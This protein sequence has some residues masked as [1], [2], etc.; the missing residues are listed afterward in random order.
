MDT[1][2][3]VGVHITNRLEEA[4]DVQ[5]VLT[6]YG[7]QIK[8]RLGLHEIEKNPEELNGLLILEMVGEEAKV[9][10]M[11]GKLNGIEGVESQ[12]MVFEHPE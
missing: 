3:I 7:N 2:R 6:T 5:K 10:E 9:H 8:T 4:V 12:C 11:I 1:H